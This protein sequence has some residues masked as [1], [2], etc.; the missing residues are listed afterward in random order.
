M[1]CPVCVGSSLVGSAVGS[2]LFG[3]HPPK[4]KQGKVIG[5][6]LTSGL[7][8]CT[9]TAIKY[10]GG[11]SICGGA[12]SLPGKITVVV[13]AGLALGILYTIPVNL[14]LSKWDSGSCSC[15]GLCDS[16]CL[17]CSGKSKKID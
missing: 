12:Q 13:I 8:T 2:Y 16:S 10:V 17:C 4:S 7:V 1:G 3:I 11:I 14:I 9:F 15:S 6:F 5:V